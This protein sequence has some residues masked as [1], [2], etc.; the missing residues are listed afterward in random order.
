MKMIEA[1]VKP[2]KFDEVKDALLEIGRAGDDGDGSQRVR[3]PEG[4]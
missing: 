2:F 3:P 1:I 4:A